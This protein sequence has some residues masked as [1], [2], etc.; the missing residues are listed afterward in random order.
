MA[1]SGVTVADTTIVAFS[2]FVKN[3]KT[4]FLIFTIENQTTITVSQKGD[5]DA[6]FEQFVEF[7]QA[8]TPG[9]GAF[10]FE[11]DTPDG[12]R[13]K[14][15]LVTWIPDTSKPRARMLYSSSKEALSSLEGSLLAIQAN[16]RSQLNKEE[17][18]QKIKQSRS[19]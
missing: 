17:V 6:T 12:P 4:R 1:L 9:Y 3:K 19:A 18:L 5:R 16:D 7:F 11:Y 15:I 13:E 2:E 8:D 10:D 14:L